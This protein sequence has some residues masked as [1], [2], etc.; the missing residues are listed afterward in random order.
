[1]KINVISTALFALVISACSSI[2]SVEEPASKTKDGLTYYLPKKDISI[3]V[4][5]DKSSKISKVDIGTTSAYPDTSKRYV[6]NHGGN[7]FG[8]NTLDVGITSS[9]L[10]TATKSTTVSNVNDAFKRLATSFGTIDTFG[11][12][13]D[14]AATAAACSKAGSHTF[15]FRAE[16]GSEDACGLTVS[17]TNLGSV[18]ANTEHTKSKGKEVSGIFYRQNEPYEV[19]VIGSGI[20]SSSIVFSPS[21]SNTYF[22]PVSKTFFA[23][24]EADFTLVDGTPTK[25]KQETGS[26]LLSFFKLPA[27]VIG[28]YFTAVGKVFD[29]FKAN[30]SKEVAALSESL[31]L[32]LAKKKYAACLIAIE[33]EESEKIKDLGCE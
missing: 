12:L 1:M 9:G 4:T 20:V 30:D 2:K 31:K 17:I 32:E 28:A 8:K 16:N 5:V 19:T 23:S 11:V 3:T 33:A 6:L 26:E 18:G 29:S 14:G 13:S 15:V 7:A 22:L 21:D 25:Y 10:L 24:N 27:D